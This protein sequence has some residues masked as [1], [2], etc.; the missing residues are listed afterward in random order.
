[1]A[2]MAVIDVIATEIVAGL[3]WTA[4]CTESHR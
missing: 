4:E 2:L 3:Y 1:M